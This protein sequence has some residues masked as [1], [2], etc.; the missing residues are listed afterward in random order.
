M[1]VVDTLEKYQAGVV[2]TKSEAGKDFIMF[3]RQLYQMY[4]VQNRSVD[5]HAEFSREL[6]RNN[7]H[8]LYHAN[9]DY[10]GEMTRISHLDNLVDHGSLKGA[11]FKKKLL[12]PARV[13]GLGSL[14][15]AAALYSHLGVASMLLG[16]TLS[17][18]TVAGATLYGLQ[19]LVEK[20]TISKIEYVKEGEYKNF[21]RV[22]VQKTPFV[23]QTILV[24]PRDT[25]SMMALGSDDIGADDCE[26]NVLVCDKFVDEATGTL[27]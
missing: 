18:L 8:W 27:Q 11:I 7:L 6:E 17:C 9:M 1:K 20:E 21:L 23:S 3:K 4:E 12:S 2:N 5:E 13:K 24:H 22:T 10:I 15:V 25:K 19:S 16:P 26:S 14:S